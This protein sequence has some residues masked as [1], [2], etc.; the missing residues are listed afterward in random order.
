MS[1]TPVADV[2]PQALETLAG[3]IGAHLR[4]DAQGW[5]IDTG[6][7][8]APPPWRMPVAELAVIRVS[9]P[10]A[11]AFLQGQ[12]T[13]DVE[14]I[15]PGRMGFAA[16]C[17]PKGRM[18]ASFL[19]SARRD[20]GFDLLLSR[21]L[22]A[23]VAKRLRMF[24]LRSKVVIDPQPDGAV[25][26]AV[27]APPDSPLVR[28]PEPMHSDD[29]GEILRLQ[30]VSLSGQRLARELHLVSDRDWHAR[31]QA[32]T[33][34]HAVPGDW[35]RSTEIMAAEARIVS[36]TGERFVPQMVNFELLGGV[37]FHKGCYTGQEVIAR[38]Q[39]LGRMKRRMMAVVGA[40]LPSPGQDLMLGD[41]PI[42]TV[43]SVGPG[44]P[45]GH[46]GRRLCLLET[47]TERVRAGAGAELPDGLQGLPL[48]YPMPE[49]KPFERPRL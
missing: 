47:T 27:V 43:V 28:V 15:A 8:D 37:D 40:S 32:L 14:S 9:G 10:D 49:H 12:L 20:G 25:P 3:H 23:G 24:V 33:A 41:E 30:D 13:A 19:V 11:A 2:R 26:I 1:E 18:L 31:W 6:A 36:A 29:A 22:V 16:H 38:S 39:N 34:A 21:D 17:S 46:A 35:F 4:Q 44:E 45:A 5:V 42:G 7:T 48:P